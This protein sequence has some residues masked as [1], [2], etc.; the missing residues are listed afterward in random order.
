MP[1]ELTLRSEKLKSIFGFPD[2]HLGH[3]VERA[4]QALALNETRADFVRFIYSSPLIEGAT[5]D[6]QRIVPSSSKHQ[7]EK[8]EDRS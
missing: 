6:M 8:R 2:K 3:H 7:L 1:E 4:Y 5:D